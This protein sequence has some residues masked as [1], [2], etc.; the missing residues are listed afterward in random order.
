MSMVFASLR[1]V[2]R[3]FRP[4]RP[5]V[6]GALL[7]LLFAPTRAAV[8]AFSARTLLRLGIVVEVSVV[9]LDPIVRRTTFGKV[10]MGCTALALLLQH[11][12]AATCPAVERVVLILALVSFSL[13]CLAACHTLHVGRMFAVQLRIGASLARVRTWRPIQNPVLEPVRPPPG[14][15]DGR[16]VRRPCLHSTARRAVGQGVYTVPHHGE[17]FLLRRRVRRLAGESPSVSGL[18]GRARGGGGAT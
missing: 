14:Y 3:P 17:L 4:C 16:G 2:P 7:L 5:C 13:P 12:L 15:G 10:A 9:H 18:A 6:L 8:G 1:G 11:P